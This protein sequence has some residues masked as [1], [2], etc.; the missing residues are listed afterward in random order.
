[1]FDVDFLKEDCRGQWSKVI[2]A[3]TGLSE[4]LFTETGKPCPLCRGIDRFAAFK[5]FNETGGVICRQCHPSGNGDGIATIMW[6]MNLEFKQAIAVLASHLG[7]DTN[8]IATGVVAEMAWRKRTG[9]DS[10]TDFGAHEADRNG[11]KVC[12]I[13]MYD[14]NMLKVADFDMAPGD[15]DKGKIRFGD[16]HGM[17]LSRRPEPGDT[18]V[19]VEGVKDAAAV[20]RELGLQAVGLPTCRMDA[21][22]ARLF[23]DC[24]VVIVPDRD[25]AGVDGARETAGRLYGVAASVSI[26]E[27]PAEFKE[28]GGAD[29]R[30]VF[31]MRD[32]VEK[33]K[34]AI[35]HAKP[36]KPGA[37]NRI[38]IRVL[39]EA[40][41]DLIGEEDQTARLLKIGLPGVDSAIGGGV[42]PSE[43][44]IIAGRPSH[45]KSVAGMQAIDTLAKSVPCLVLSE[46]MSYRQLASRATCGI[47]DIHSGLWKQ[48]CEAVR[49]S[50]RSHYQQR[51]P[52][53]IVESSGTVDQAIKTIELCVEQHKIGAVMVDYMQLLR[54]TGSSRYEQVSDVS[55]KLKQAAVRLNLVLIAVCQ[56]NRSVETRGNS[57][58]TTTPR[59]S[60]LRDSGQLEQ[61]TDVILFVEWL[62]RTS[63]A[64]HGKE[65]YRINIAKNRNRAIVGDGFVRCLF[66]SERQ[67]LFAIAREEQS[68]YEPA[69]SDTQSN[70]DF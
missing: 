70:M 40:V 50:A 31:A 35:D 42:L 65:D 12:R 24:K 60:D 27:L 19:M 4:D 47:T 36:W 30:D 38:V 1:M 20:Q 41:H 28:S 16:K 25:K 54:G 8:D 22:F 6:A 21:T 14:A 5:D 34:A 57:R 33:A 59:M 10:L 15:L 39:S 68:F 18:V 69:F 55:T 62:W 52:I 56:L 48:N 61:D 64:G 3:I 37:E 63:P 44:I 43:M 9:L 26:A 2:S 32:G 66:K 58:E 11:V 29:V 23:R 53:Y 13:P 51:E 7:Y 46:E 49:F 67:R 45:G 17:F